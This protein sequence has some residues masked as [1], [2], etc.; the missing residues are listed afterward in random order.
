MSAASIKMGGHVRVGDLVFICQPESLILFRG[1]IAR[2]FAAPAWRTG[3][4]PLAK[5]MIVTADSRLILWLMS[6]STAVEF[7][8]P[9]KHGE[10]WKLRWQ[11]PWCRS[12][13]LHCSGLKAFGCWPEP[14]GLGDEVAFLN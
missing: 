9:W 11:Q 4:A 6:G 12:S 3:Y 1:A 13:Q 7:P 8:T 10:A 14:L 5:V 2:L